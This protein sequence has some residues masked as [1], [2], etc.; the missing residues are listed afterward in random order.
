MLAA[1]DLTYVFVGALVGLLE[2]VRKSWTIVLV[3]QFFCK[4]V[5]HQWWLIGAAILFLGVH[6]GISF[7]M[8]TTKDNKIIFKTENVQYGGLAWK[9]KL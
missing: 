9:Q 1:E 8:L 5:H 7:I 2:P 4:H 6:T 3:G